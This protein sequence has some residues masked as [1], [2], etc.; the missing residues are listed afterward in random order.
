MVAGDSLRLI[1]ELVDAQMKAATATNFTPQAT[2]LQTNNF[3]GQLS[4]DK[5]KVTLPDG[6]EF[7]AVIAGNPEVLDST[8]ILNSHEAMHVA[9]LPKGIR[10]SSSSSAYVIFQTF[11]I[12]GKNLY[13]LAKHS[14]AADPTKYYSI[15][16]LT[17]AG[18]SDGFSLFNLAYVRFSKNTNHI[19]CAMDSGGSAGAHIKWGWAKGWSLGLDTHGN[20]V[21]KWGSLDQKTLNLDTT[22]LPSPGFPGAPGPPPDSPVQPFFPFGPPCNFSIINFGSFINSSLSYSFSLYDTTVGPK[23]DVVG[24][25][26]AQ[27][28]SFNTFHSSPGVIAGDPFSKQNSLSHTYLFESINAAAPNP[29]AIMFT[30]TNTSTPPTTIPFNGWNSLNVATSYT[31]SV[32]S[33]GDVWDFYPDDAEA[34]LFKQQLPDLSFVSSSIKADSDT[35][36]IYWIPDTGSYIAI[37]TGV[38][39]VPNLKTPFLNT[40]VLLF[41]DDIGSPPPTIY[42]RPAAW[43]DAG[44]NKLVQAASS[45]AFVS[46]DENVPHAPGPHI[47]KFQIQKWGWDS[48][49]LVPTAGKF[50]LGDLWDTFGYVLQDYCIR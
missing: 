19:F 4:A 39:T 37:S 31:N 2:Q 41:L 28:V 36:N 29:S 13:W 50:L 47:Q 30:Q 6:R 7:D 9:D 46:M 38:Y 34:F 20:R 5:T 14:E 12:G 42:D 32:V 43:V 21:V 15:D 23:A 18:V 48:V 33:A 10:R 35:G 11:D 24:K 49:H 40:D 1:R 3:L 16:T 45:Q 44:H 27:A 25:W 22:T 17:I 8:I 26:F